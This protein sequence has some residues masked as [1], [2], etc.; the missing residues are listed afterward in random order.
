MEDLFTT[1]TPREDL[2]KQFDSLD[3]QVTGLQKA[4][5][6]LSAHHPTL[7]ARARDDLRVLTDD[8]HFIVSEGDDSPERF[9]Q[10]LARQA[11]AIS[12]SAKKLSRTAQYVLG[13]TSGRG[14]LLGDMQRLA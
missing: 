10:V 1:T 13:E 14:E 12:D 3:D 8:L 2:Y 6:E 11:K 4:M 5:S 7:P 9:R